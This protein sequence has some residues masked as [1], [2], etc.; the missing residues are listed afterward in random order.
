MTACWLCDQPIVAPVEV[1]GRCLAADTR[2][3]HKACLTRLGEL[4]LAFEAADR[5]AGLG[6]HP[7]EA[8]GR[9]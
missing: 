8:P 2:V 7:R 4:E 5:D 3:V 9:P 1:V 6:P